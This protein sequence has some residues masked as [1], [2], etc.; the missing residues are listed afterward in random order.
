M[1]HSEG[2]HG[3]TGPGIMDLWRWQV[4][5]YLSI[6]HAIQKTRDV[7]ANEQRGLADTNIDTDMEVSNPCTPNSSKF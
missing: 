2:E 6:Q 5:R 7:S 4:E 3:R 1:E